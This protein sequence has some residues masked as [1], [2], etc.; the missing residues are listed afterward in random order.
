MVHEQSHGLQQHADAVHRK[1]PWVYDREV[2]DTQQL[3]GLFLLS[4]RFHPWELAQF[5]TKSHV[6]VDVHVGIQSIVLEYHGDV[7]VFRRYIIN[8]GVADGDFARG[9]LLQTCNHSQRGGF[10]TARRSNQYDKLPV[11]NVRLMLSTAVTLPKRLVM[12]FKITCAN[13]KSPLPKSGIFQ[14][15][16]AQRPEHIN[17]RSNNNTEYFVWQNKLADFYWRI[18]TF[19]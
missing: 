9:N 12:F 5:Q 6:V 15:C 2:L 7:P 10:T 1:V 14:I 19:T 17:L 18:S 13:E 4:C 11:L 3:S 8:H 16:L